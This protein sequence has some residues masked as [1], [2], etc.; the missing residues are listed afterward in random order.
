M[1]IITWKTKLII[2]AIIIA[3]V[4]AGCGIVSA[5]DFGSLL[6]AVTSWAIGVGCGWYAKYLYNTY[7]VKQ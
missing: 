6:L 7:F 2:A 1:K 4:L 3:L 5:M